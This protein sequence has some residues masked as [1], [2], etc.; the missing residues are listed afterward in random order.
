VRGRARRRTQ[1]AAAAAAV[2][3]ALAACSGGA[4]DARDA[5]DASVST[6]TAPT[7][8]AAPTTTTTAT[9]AP[10]TAPTTTAPTTTAP[11]TTT[12]PAADRL[13]PYRGLGTWVDVFDSEPAFQHPAGADPPVDV[14]ALGEMYRR[15]VRT[16]YLQVAKDEPRSPGVL[17]N[18]AH[19]AEWLRSAHAAGIKVVAWYL[20]THRDP[21]LDERRALA[22]ARFES[23][24]ERFDG[25]ALDIEGTELA[26]VAER[27]R[28]LL[29]LVRTLDAA[30]GD[31]A[32]GA[33]VYPPVATDVLNPALWPEFPW[34]QVAPHVDVWLPMSYWTYRAADSP[35]RDA[36]RYTVENV[37]RVRAHVGNPQLPVHPIGGIADKATDADHAAFVRA[38]RD[39]GAIGVSVY[40]FHTTVA[41][42]W[43]SLRWPSPS[44]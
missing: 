17:A 30:A 23:G 38:G 2:A 19:A 40:D 42:A 15:G 34:K 26:D 9:T 27:N 4:R 13:C 20:P 16:L 22:L 7:T 3:L 12:A 33:I 11:T 14:D 18:P 5:S 39:T 21:A 41:S 25:I 29:A 10:T 37:R 32:I 31:I 43:S 36:Y 35:W 8:T 1:H 44:C 6:T 28:R 24:G